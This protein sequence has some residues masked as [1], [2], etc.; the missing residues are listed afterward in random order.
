MYMWIIYVGK[1]VKLL[2]K[3]RTD[4][5]KTTGQPPCNDPGGKKS[6]LTPT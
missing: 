3:L 5:G 6:D 4:I 1:E 2:E